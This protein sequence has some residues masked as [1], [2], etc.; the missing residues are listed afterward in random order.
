MPY[1]HDSPPPRSHSLSLLISAV[2]HSTHTES[3]IA[4]GG[5]ST[6]SLPQ[7]LLELGDEPHGVPHALVVAVPIAHQTD[8]IKGCIYMYI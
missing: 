1:A 2:P 8:A 7:Q 4:R 3:I 6:A 5:S